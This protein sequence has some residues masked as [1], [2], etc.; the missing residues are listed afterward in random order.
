MA[1]VQARLTGRGRDRPKDG[2]RQVVSLLLAAHEKGLDAVERACAEALEAGL[3]SADAI[4][5]ILS[6]QDRAPAVET[7]VPPEQLQLRHEPT[8]DC[9]R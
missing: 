7:V 9:A 5:N 6:R 8:A 1:K 3:R 4:L 2:D